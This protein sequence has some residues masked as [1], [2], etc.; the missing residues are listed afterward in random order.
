[1]EDPDFEQILK[2]SS[3]NVDEVIC[4][5]II[6]TYSFRNLQNICKEKLQICVLLYS[7][8][9]VIL[10]FHG[11]YELFKALHDPLSFEKYRIVVIKLKN[12]PI[13]YQ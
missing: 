7:M 12:L 5:R 1:M 6:K 8:H 4:S 13:V 10:Y 2:P 3:F 9:S 11:I